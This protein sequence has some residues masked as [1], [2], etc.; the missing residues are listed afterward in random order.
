MK[1]RL[2]SFNLFG[3]EFTFYSDASDEEV[4]AVIRLLRDE[5][6]NE[7]TMTRGAIPSSKVLVLG[8]LRLAARYVLLEQEVKKSRKEQEQSVARLI[9]KVSATLGQ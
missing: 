8:S 9:D 1:E 2:V 7:K 6:E 4:E 5:L 3:Q